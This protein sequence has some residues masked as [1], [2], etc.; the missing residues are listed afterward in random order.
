MTPGVCSISRGVGSAAAAWTPA[1]VGA[2][3]VVNA[4]AAFG[5]RLYQDVA[6]TSLVTTAGQLVR[7]IVQEDGLTPD[8]TQSG[9]TAAGYLTTTSSGL[10][11]I[12][13]DNIDDREASAQT[14]SAGAKSI[15]LHWQ[16]HTVLGSSELDV[17][18]TL[19]ATPSQFRLAIGGPTAT[20]P[21]V[22]FI[23]DVA[24]SSTSFTKFAW[25]PDTNEH[26]LLICYNGG[27]IGSA[28]SYRAWLDGVEQTLSSGSSSTA[29]GTTSLGAISVGSAAAGIKVA[30]AFLAPS[31]LSSV[32]AAVHTWL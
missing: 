22:Q 12:G 3:F 23:C 1:S 5:S 11:A 31:D 10:Y 4:P 7:A 6:K 27:S 8:L 32:Q 18:L 2:T 28:A 25:T 9:A 30:R 20:F 21:G 14:F 15:G 16:Y 26:T 29:S 19:G 17:P 24:G 13:H